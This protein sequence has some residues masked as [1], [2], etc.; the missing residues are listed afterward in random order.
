MELSDNQKVFVIDAEHQEFKVDHGYSGRNM[1]GKTCPAVRV[2]GIGD[3]RTMAQYS[4]D[5]MGKGYVI[6]CPT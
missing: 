6:Y 1:Y 5:N 4:S 2:D 3:F